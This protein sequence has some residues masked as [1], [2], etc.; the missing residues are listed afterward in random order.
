MGGEI[1]VVV[2]E[3]SEAD[4][5][6]MVTW[7]YGGD[8]A[9]YDFREADRATLLDPA[10][11][12]L[13]IRQ[14]GELIGHVC[15]GVEARVAGMTEDPQLV[16]LGV[17]M[18]PDVAGRGESRRLMPALMAALERQLGTVSFRAVI[19]AWNTRA[20]RAAEHAGFTV[21]GQLEN[22]AGAWMLLTRPAP[23]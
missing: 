5:D 19:K 8:Y 7:R 16:D 15:L 6:S 20:L 4:I 1:R 22:E 2:D 17:G 21:S 13:G 12:F 11:Q 23:R 10:N 14:A 18:R 3:L 9:L